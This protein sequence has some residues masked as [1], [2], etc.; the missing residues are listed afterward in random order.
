MERP[1]F[2]G[3]DVTVD[4]YLDAAPEPQQGTLRALRSTLRE[5]LPQAAETIS[6]GVPAFLV[7]GKPVAGYAWA[8]RHC[9]FYP[10]SGAVLVQAQELLR[11]F[12]W[13]KGTLRFP[14]DEPLPAELVEH[15]V[16]LKLAHLEAGK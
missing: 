3:R 1:R 8:K 16:E 12:D 2:K 10:H 7:D 5:L 14:V 11:G 9:S 15:L 4:E 6:Y 13:G